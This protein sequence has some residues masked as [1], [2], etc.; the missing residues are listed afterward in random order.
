MTSVRSFCASQVHAYVTRERSIEDADVVA[1]HVFGLHHLPRTEDF[2]LQ[3]V[4]TT[5]FK[6]IP[7]GFFS[8]NPTLDLAPAKNETSCHASASE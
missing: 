1:W 8:V 6:L 2:P 7:S 5:G 4:V 3:P